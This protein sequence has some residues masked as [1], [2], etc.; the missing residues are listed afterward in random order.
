MSSQ[1]RASRTFGVWAGVVSIVT[2]AAA[3]PFVWLGSIGLR[4]VLILALS[5]ITQLVSGATL[6]YAALAARDTDQLTDD[7]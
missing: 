5:I 4:T 6:L 3:A 2:G 7:G 1:P